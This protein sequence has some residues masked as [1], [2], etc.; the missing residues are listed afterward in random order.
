MMLKKFRCLALVLALIL[1]VVSCTTFAAAKKQI[2]LVY[3][4]TF[5]RDHFYV[6][7]DLKFKELVEKQSKGSI[8]IDYFPTG[9]LGTNVEMGQATKTGAQQL[10]FSSIPWTFFPKAQTIELPYIFRDEAHQQKVA[11]RFASLFD[12]AEVAA[13]AGVHI[14]GA[15]LSSA[16]HLVTKTPVNKVAD[17]KGLKIRV[18]ESGMFL[19][20][21]RA[22][23]AI[24]TSIPG[25]DTYTALATG[26]VD[27][28]EN[29]FADIYAWKYYE[30]LKYCALTGHVRAIYVMMIND[31]C[32]KSL[33]KAQ[34]KIIAKAAVESCEY[35]ETLRKK[36][37]GEYKELL[38]K[39]GMKF[40][41]PDTVPFREKAKTMWSQFGDEEL[42][43]KIE[44]VK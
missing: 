24:P 33:T 5:P 35:S 27:A 19:A 21:W 9:Q 38:A 28:A 17:L 37:E 7:A 1:V 42:I 25:P 18:P 13:K 29:P 22:M 8:L 10:F 26:T 39:E 31:K 12:E 44:A 30:Q 4:N 41:T 23:G 15:R 16:R 34:Q 32:W 14:L 11:K 2:K 43:K 6:K 20:M 3:G 40:T 36:V